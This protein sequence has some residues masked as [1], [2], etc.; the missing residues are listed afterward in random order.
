MTPPNSAPLSRSP[1]NSIPVQT[2]LPIGKAFVNLVKPA[3]PPV[4]YLEFLKFFVWS[5][6]V[7]ITQLWRDLSSGKFYKP[8]LSTD[9]VTHYFVSVLLPFQKSV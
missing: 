9:F 2:Q 7:V 5:I 6:M 4:T 8:L 1:S 3:E